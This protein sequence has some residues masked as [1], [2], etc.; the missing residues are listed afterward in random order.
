[1]LARPQFT[2]GVGCYEIE[3]LELHSR[4]FYTN[5]VYSTAYRG[6]GHLETH[7]VIERQMD[8]IAQIGMDPYEF[9]KKNILKEGSETI[10][11]ERISRST[12][13][14]AIALMLSL[15]R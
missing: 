15:R 2:P 5:K 12:G 3:N 14:L 6:F 4:T 7:W 11:G 10:S 13:S 9:R 1:M 8:L